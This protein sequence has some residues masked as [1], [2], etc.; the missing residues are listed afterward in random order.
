MTS[1]APKTVNY[2]FNWILKNADYVNITNHPA[3]DPVK[4]QVFQ[5]KFDNCVIDW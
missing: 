3:S 2:K 4:T 5:T 1:A